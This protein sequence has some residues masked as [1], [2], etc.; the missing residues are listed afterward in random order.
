MINVNNISEFHVSNL[1]MESHP[2]QHKC[3]FVF[4]DGK[5]QVS[6]VLY[7]S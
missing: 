1:C 5:P 4:A 2:C 7:T 6:V 3:W